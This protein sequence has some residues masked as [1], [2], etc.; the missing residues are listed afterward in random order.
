MKDNVHQVDRT[1]AESFLRTLDPEATRWT[2]QTFDDDKERKNK[3]LAR[4][5]HGTLAERWEELRR[6]NAQGAGIFVTINETDLKGRSAENIIRIRSLFIDLDGAPLE[7]VIADSLLT[8]PHIISES[9]PGKWQCFHLMKGVK[10]E[11]FKALQLEL[12]SRFHGDPLVHDLPRVMRLPGFFHQ[13]NPQAPH[14]VRIRTINPAEPVDIEREFSATRS[15]WSRFFFHAIHAKHPEPDRLQPLP[16]WLHDLIGDDAGK[17]VSQHADDLPAPVSVAKIKAALAAVPRTINHLE[18]LSIGCGLLKELGSAQGFEVFDAWC[19]T[20]KELY[21]GRDQVEG[22][23]RSF[24]AKDGY[25]YGIGS[26]FRIADQADSTWRTRHRHGIAEAPKTGNLIQSSREFVGGFVP[27]FYLIDGLLQQQFVYCVTGMTGHGKTTVMLLIAAH[28]AC[29]LP[30]DKREV[31]KARVLFFAGENPDDIRMRWIKLCEEMN[32]DA[33]AMDVFFLPGTPPISNAEIRKRIDTEAARHG[34]FGL[35]I[36][37]TSAA[38][39]QGDDENSNA[40]LGAHARMLR[41]FV[42][43]PGGPTVVVTAHPPKNPNMDNMLPRGGGAFLNEMDGNLVCINNDGVVTVHWHGKFRGPDF[44]PILFKLNPGTSDKLKDAK[45]RLI[46]TVTAAPISEVEKTGL[47]NTGRRRQDELLVLLSGNPHLSL[48]EMAVK[49]G[50]MNSKGEP[51][52]TLVNRTL[53]N[54]IKDKLIERKR[55]RIVL[56]KDGEKV[57]KDSDIM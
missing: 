19:S 53:A 17:G 30:L 33:A 36:I 35:L 43:L 55:D 4:V 29:G 54:L 18:W 8:H 22:Q 12:A 23:W 41:T 7:P 20:D 9:S 56:T 34:P 2:F 25:G 32:L 14:L 52:R 24:I 15:G 31:E 16:Q 51:N 45:G 28:V 1:E 38:Y 37:D 40:Q 6:L 26:L 57:V 46:W 13:K 47:E 21:Q 27:P 10:K 11:N 42:N 44:A 3:K 50:W 39:F 5:I 48:A 49:L